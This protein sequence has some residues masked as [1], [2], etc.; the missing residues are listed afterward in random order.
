[1]CHIWCLCSLCQTLSP[2]IGRAF[3]T[4]V[5]LRCIYIAVDICNVF[6]MKLKLKVSIVSTYIVWGRFSINSRLNKGPNSD[7]IR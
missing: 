1:M 5:I 3:Y 6:F 4:Y 7:E 2:C